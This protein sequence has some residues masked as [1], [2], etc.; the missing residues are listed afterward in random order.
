MINLKMLLETAAERKASDMLL[1]VGLP[2][3]VRIDGE[4]HPLEMEPL[5]HDVIRRMVGGILNERQQ[6]RY[7]ELHEIDLSLSATGVGRFRVNVYQ[8]RG[9]MAAAFRLIPSRPPSF[10]ELGLP[11]I[12]RHFA[13]MT[14][15]LI[16]VTGATGQGK[17]TTQA[18]M[19]DYINQRRR[20]HIV[21]IEDPIEYVHEHKMSAIDQREVGTDT[22]SFAQALKAALRQDPDVLLV[23]EMRDLETIS[24]VL[25][26]AETGHLVITT[27]HTNDAVQS[28]DRI[29]DVYPS[30]QQQQIRVQLAFCLV[31]ILSQP[32]IPRHP[33]PGRIAAVE[34]M[35]NNLAIANVIREGKTHKAHNIMQTHSKEGMKT[36]DMALGE[37]YRRDLITFEEAY[38]RARHPRSME[39][40]RRE[41]EARGNAGGGGASR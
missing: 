31:G 10:S 40:L 18:A 11:P 13:E 9:V 37:L 23:G 33:G 2:P 34:V 6:A 14:Q 35:V 19:I 24:T 1:T 25:T 41:K 20:V 17:S 4:L 36:M 32:L 30:H 38:R 28:I 7:A 26:A 5:T 22:P 27:L 15:G 21:T 16:L 29:V 39:A 12:V 8:Q 3:M